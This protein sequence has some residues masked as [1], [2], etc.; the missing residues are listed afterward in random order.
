MR[1]EFPGRFS[2]SGEAFMRLENNRRW[3]DRSHG[4]SRVCARVQRTFERATFSC[5]HNSMIQVYGKS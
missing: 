3:Q 2:L 1:K 4:L 5:L